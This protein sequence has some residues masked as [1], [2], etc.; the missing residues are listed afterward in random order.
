MNEFDQFMK[1]DLRVKH[2][3]RYTDDFIVIANSLV[4]LKSLLPS[5]ADFLA[6]RLALGLHPHKVT[7]RPAHQGIDFLGYIIFLHHRLLRTRTR[8]RILKMLGQR[9][10]DHAQQLIT[11]Y[12][13]RQ[14]IQS[15]LGALSHANSY[16]FAQEIKNKY[17]V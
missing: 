3:V 12:S 16:R 1:H 4:Y 14:T 11:D 2:Y 9:A 7:F 17:W 15:Y 10:T 13:F 8:K 6:E 5:I